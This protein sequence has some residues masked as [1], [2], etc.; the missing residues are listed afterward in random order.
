MVTTTRPAP[1]LPDAPIRRWMHP[2]LRFM[3][4]EQTSGILLLICTVIALGMSNS[5]WA[6]DWEHFWHLNVAFSVGSWTMDGSLSH[7]INDGLMV[8]FFFVVGM[9]VKREMVLGELRNPRKAALPI[10]GAL[11]G[12]VVPAGIYLALQWGEPGQHGWGI[13]TATD[14]AFVVGFLSL[15]GSRVPPGLKMFLLTLA[16]VDDIGA[17]LLIAIFYSGDV[18]AGLLFAGL[19]GC[20]LCVVFNQV[21]VRRI[22]VYTIVGIGVWLAFFHSNVHPTIAG[23]M[24]GLLT[25]TQAW[26]GLPDLRAAIE[27]AQLRLKSIEGTHQ[28]QTDWRWGV[29][30]LA[31]RE[32]VA[33]LERL[34]RALHPWVAFGI[35]PLFALANAGVTVEPQALEGGVSLACALGLVVGKSFGI[36][37]FSWLAVRSGFA[38]LPTGVNLKVLFG[39]ACFG[40]IGFTMALFIANLALKGELLASAKVGVLAGSTVAVL[41]GVGWLYFTLPRRVEMPHHQSA[42]SLQPAPS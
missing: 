8:L 9:E 17:V 39:G 36:F 14:I 15:L 21:G 30:A 6:H 28:P 42:T 27:D 26:V 22:P 2:L 10:F 1:F 20:L 35:M 3:E 16:I 37:F 18:N 25:P 12:M 23:V 40:G 34:E 24:L 29:L 33:P 7:W 31:A 13:P 11:G 19:G 5:P 32:A 41:L 4:I 38:Q